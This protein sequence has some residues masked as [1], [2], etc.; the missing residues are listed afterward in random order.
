MVVATFAFVV[1]LIA[2]LFPQG[3]G[4]AGLCFAVTCL[5]ASAFAA[6]AL[7]GNQTEKKAHM[8]QG[9]GLPNTSPTGQ[10]SLFRSGNGRGDVSYR[11]D[12]S[13]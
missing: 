7:F 8:I 12:D 9:Q 13:R 6:W 4:W 10:S 3:A 2:W 11:C 5:Y 1:L